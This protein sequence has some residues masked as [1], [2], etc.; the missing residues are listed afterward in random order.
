MKTLDLIL[1]VALLVACFSP[2]IGAET[3][4][5]VDNGASD[6]VI[7]LPK[8]ASPSEKW[9]AEELVSHIKQMTGAEL[10]IVPQAAQVP[11]KAIV[12]GDG[13]AARSLG[14]KI[15]ANVLGTDGYIIK[16]L[17]DRL[18]IAGGRKCGTMYGVFTLLERLGVRWWTPTETHIPKAA[19]VKAPAMDLREVPRLEYR[20][21]LFRQVWDEPGRVWMA[22]NKLNGPLNKGTPA[23]RGGQYEYGG[24][25][26]LAHT[27]MRLLAKHKIEI[28][29]EMMSADARGRRARPGSRA[30][31]LCFSSDAAVQAMTQAVVAEYR[32]RPDIRFVVV[33]QEDGYNYCRC[34]KCQAVAKAEGSQSGPLIQFVNRVAENA[35]KQVPG[36]AVA[37]NAYVW[38]RKPPR[39][40]RPRH[41]V[42][43]VLC[44]Y[45]C[46]FADPLA[47]ST[48]KPNVEFRNDLEAW[49]RLS[50]KLIVWDYVTNF[51]HYLMPHPNLDVLAPNVKYFADHGVVGVMA[52][53]QWNC[54]GAEFTQLR[55]W[56]LAKAMWDP[57][58]D[59]RALI[60]EFLAGYYGP[61]A[62]AVQKYI[63]VTHRYMREHTDWVLNIY[64]HLNVPYIAPE[65]VA[66]AEAALREAD[67]AVA[68]KGEDL[69]RRVRHAHMPVW[70]LLTKCGPGSKMWRATEAKV[71]TLDMARL[72]EQFGQVVKDYQIN[73]VAEGQQG[74]A[75]FEWLADYGKLV[76]ARGVPV[77]EELRGRDP[78]SYRL[79]QAC[80]MDRNAN[81]FVPQAGAT[82]GWAAKPPTGRQVLHYLSDTNDYT[83]GRTYRAFV[84]VRGEGVAGDANGPAW[85]CSLGS[86]PAVE[87]TAE[88]LRDGNWHTFEI[89]TIKPRGIGQGLTSGLL[90][91][92][93]GKVKSIYIDCFWLLEQPAAAK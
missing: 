22:H 83:P 31:Q 1:A 17:G 8:D 41:N 51:L 4:T 84:R 53:G 33:G 44:T 49:S 38:S 10:R 68:G 80:Q 90:Y 39:N 48:V 92:Y 29:P 9:A 14:V 58:A 62:P 21:L 15:D 16:T 64:R 61:A 65:I 40:I 72:A 50:G 67:E 71:G 69:E 82:D 36:T 70:Y 77:P 42:C 81:W 6:C 88:Q 76:A 47:T 66:E 32:Q 55:G 25:G 91:K 85:T 20:D 87:V 24:S 23:K 45:E 19:T 35:E 57:N 37:T 30:D 27:M 93:R 18:V 5:L 63:D 59:N 26:G 89:G 86:R 74:K 52:Q 34:E 43:I 28:T 11:A 2:V 78:N 56:V 13:P 12:I 73:E 3:I 46:S 60:S 79:I 7:A 54:L 75:F